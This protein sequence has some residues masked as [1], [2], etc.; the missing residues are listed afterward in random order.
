[1]LVA[2]EVGRRADDAEVDVAVVVED[3]AAARAAPD[4]LDGTIRVCELGELGEVCFD[5]W[6]LV[7]PEHDAR[8]VDIQEKDCR[9]GRR[10]LQQV[11]LDREVEERVGRV[12]EVDLD[13]VTWMR[14]CNCRETPGTATGLFD[15]EMCALR[16][17]AGK[18]GVGA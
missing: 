15:E 4:K 18:H 14:S 5:P 16:G 13:L 3:G 10:R 7:A 6:V 17:P 12:R 11:V 2:V 8:R 1:M 9:V